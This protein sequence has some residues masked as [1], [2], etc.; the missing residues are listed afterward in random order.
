MGESNEF[1]Y[2]EI[3]ILGGNEMMENRHQALGLSDETSIRNV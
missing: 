3:K 2:Y 1:I